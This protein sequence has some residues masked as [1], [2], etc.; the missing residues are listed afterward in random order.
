MNNYYGLPSGKVEKNETFVQ[1][2]IREAEEE[3]GAKLTTDNLKYVHT[4]H[5]LA[6][7]PWVDVYFEVIN[8]GGCLTNA[9]PHMHSKLDWLDVNN[10]PNN[11]I[12]AVK[13]ALFEINHGRLFSQF[14]Y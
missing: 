13:H 10:L 4:V 5:R 8:Y 12:P 2:A 9:E 14:N 7:D 3:V 6:D 1:A 11:I